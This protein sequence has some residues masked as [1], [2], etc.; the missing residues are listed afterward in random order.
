MT[1]LSVVE[2][3]VLLN[4]VK[5]IRNINIKSEKSEPLNLSQSL[6]Q[7]KSQTSTSARFTSVKFVPAIPLLNINQKKRKACKQLQSNII[8]NLLEEAKENL[9]KAYKYTNQ[10]EI[11]QALK[12]VSHAINNTISKELNQLIDSNQ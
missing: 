4:S 2:K 10:E 9:L 8:K 5:I 6:N 1:T 3:K 7:S 12:H 11:L